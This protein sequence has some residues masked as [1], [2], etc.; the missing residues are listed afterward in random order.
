MKLAVINLTAGGIS[1]GH[2]AYIS[3]ILPRLAASPG[4][5]K[6]LCASP[7]S[8][9]AA[10]WIPASPK[11]KLVVCEPFKFLRPA[12]GRKLKAELDA[13]GPD[14]IFVSIERHLNYPGVP[15]MTIVHNMAPLV[16][17]KTTVGLR[18]KVQ[19]WARRLETGL[20]VKRASRVIVPTAFV[21]DSIISRF[22][23]ARERTAL[24][25]FGYA[26]EAGMS[27]PAPGIMELLAGGFV[28]SA[29]SFEIYRGYED[30]LAAYAGV[31]RSFPNIKLVIVGGTRPATEGFKMKLQALAVSLGVS[32][33]VL[34]PEHVSREELGWYYAHSSVFALT[35]RVESFCFIA[36][37]A[38]AHGCV[39]VCADNPCLPEI[40][41]EAAVYYPPGDSHAL[42]VSLS[43]ALS[44]PE[45]ERLRVSA[46]AVS[47]ASS[48]S[49]D[50]AAAR[51]LELLAGVSSSGVKT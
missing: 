16:D 28:F 13:F 8:F 34:W 43:R 27:A 40:C 50:L 4:I 37:E 46:R 19:S 26:P 41:G 22:G 39:C 12:P 47:R 24:I 51:T 17:I 35:S 10:S 14:V 42:S 18:E 21:R 32:K 7:A 31:K 9:N 36:L 49:W 30:L 6:I 25:P 29:G 1:G 2:K 44:L 48:F 45:D 3:G 20:A 15:I 5:E 23:I 33:D 11:V 38:M